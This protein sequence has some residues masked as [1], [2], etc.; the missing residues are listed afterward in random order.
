IDHAWSNRA[1]DGKT[2]IPGTT[3]AADAANALGIM[4]LKDSEYK[5]LQRLL[6]ASELL[7]ARWSRDGNRIIRRTE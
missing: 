4:K 7:R 2:F 3:A 1:T 6:D 5:T